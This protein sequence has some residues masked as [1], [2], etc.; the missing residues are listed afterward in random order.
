MPKK[1]ICGEF[2]GHRLRVENTWFSG[3]QLYHNDACI[4]ANNDLFALNRHK[5]VMTAKLML[6]NTV[7]T[8]EV[9]AYAILVVKIKITVDGEQIAGDSF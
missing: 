6:D 2:A 7:R 8:V 4:A 5:A 3:A 9:F 1:T